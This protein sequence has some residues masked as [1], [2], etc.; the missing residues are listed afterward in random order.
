M[1]KLSFEHCN[2]HAIAE[3]E[4]SFDGTSFF[5]YHFKCKPWWGTNFITF[6]NYIVCMQSTTQHKN[7]KSSPASSVYIWSHKYQNYFIKITPV[8]WWW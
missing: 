5:S 2:V 7:D 8:N 3:K 1:D 4:N 6:Y